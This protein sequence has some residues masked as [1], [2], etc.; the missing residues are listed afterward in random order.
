M[1]EGEG[2]G[3]AH[4]GA[5]G[6]HCMALDPAFCG[7]GNGSGRFQRGPGATACRRRSTISGVPGGR[8]RPG[9]EAEAPGV[10]DAL[11][12]ATSGDGQ[13]A[14]ADAASTTSWRTSGAFGGEALFA[15]VRRTCRR[16]GRGRCWWRLSRGVPC[17]T[18]SNKARSKCPQCDG[19]GTQVTVCGGRGTR[20][21]SGGGRTGCAR[22]S[23]R[24]ETRRERCAV[25]GARRSRER[26]GVP[27]A[28]G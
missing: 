12:S 17:N 4:G 7:R 28:R 5:A 15:P 24:P 10:Q 21:S 25:R 8:K 16:T 14:G 6:E 9:G 13:A 3:R 2:R 18:C 23:A 20:K 1:R 26:C 19:Q 27:R 11:D 22:R